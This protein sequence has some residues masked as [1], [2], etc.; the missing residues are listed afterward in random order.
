MTQPKVSTPIP[1]P[2]PPMKFATLRTIFAL[3]LREM[4]VRYGK[5]PGGYIWAVLEPVGMIIVLSWGFSLIMR[6][7]ALGTSFILFY[8]TGILAL[9]LYQ[10]SARKV[11]QALNYSRAL[12][13]Y[14]AVTWVDAI[15][16]RFMLNLL[17]S[18]M[19]TYLILTGILALED[20]RS[21]LTFQPILLAITLAA[22][23]GLGIGCM[24]CYLMSKYMIW[25]QIWGIATRPLF[26]AS[27]IFYTYE[28]LP[29]TAQAILWYNPLMHVTALMRAGFYPTYSPDFVSIPYTL[30][31]VLLPMCFGVIM[32]RK[33]HRS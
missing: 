31:W 13:A 8:A 9:N 15:L 10:T 16:A 33:M 6:S 29:S 28:I 26:L 18:V 32:L 20:T 11:A 7:P 24:N 22:L 23:I 5:S 4:S 1:P 3:V 2:L 17:T 25:K 21:I 27:G 12:L 30:A 19:V 14:P